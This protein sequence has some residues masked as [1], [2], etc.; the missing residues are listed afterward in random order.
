M[1][2]LSC[3]HLLIHVNLDPLTIMFSQTLEFQ[4]TLNSAIV[5][6]LTP[7]HV[8]DRVGGEVIDSH[9]AQNGSHACL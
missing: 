6:W 8:S 3:N 9:G 2:C 4:L 5:Q 1:C 7:A